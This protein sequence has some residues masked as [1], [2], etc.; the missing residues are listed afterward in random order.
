MNDSANDPLTE[1]RDVN[2][3]GT[4]NFA[5]QAAD[6]KMKRFIFISSVKVNGE[7]TNLGTPFTA[8]DLPK[9]LDPYSIFKLEAAVGLKQL[10]MESGMEIVIIRPPL[11][12]GP[13]V[14]ANFLSMMRWINSGVP[15][16][17]GAIHNKRSLVALD[18]LVDLIVTCIDHPC[19]ANQTFLAGDGEDLSTTELLQKIGRALGKPSRLVPL[20]VSLLTLVASLL[21]KR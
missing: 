18:N 20:P 9:A 16:P 4:L 10:S 3:K 17:L 8:D 19:A 13:G 2:V 11:D 14:S 6:A 12:Y 5:R 21:G 7:A 15:L 1:F